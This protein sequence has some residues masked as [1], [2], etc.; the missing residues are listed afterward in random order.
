MVDIVTLAK[1]EGH[2]TLGLII[3]IFIALIHLAIFVIYLSN[4]KFTWVKR[5]IRFK[6]QRIKLTSL[7]VPKIFDDFDTHYEDYKEIVNNY[8]RNRHYL[9]NHEYIQE[10][11]DEMMM[12]REIKPYNIMV[13]FRDVIADD[14]TKKSTLHVSKSYKFESK[15]FNSKLKGD[16]YHTFNQDDRVDSYLFQNPHLN[17][18]FDKNKD[19]TDKYAILERNRKRTMTMLCLIARR[20]ENRSDT[21]VMIENMNQMKNKRQ[22]DQDRVLSRF[23]NIDEHNTAANM[24]II[25]PMTVHHPKSKQIIGQMGFKR[26][27]LNLI[28]SDAD[29]DNMRLMFNGGGDANQTFEDS[30]DIKQIKSVNILNKL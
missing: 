3:I 24:K 20:Q 13:D 4:I 18:I 26:E 25:N 9:L 7:D 29:N 30:M 1:A 5:Y 19:I 8:K 6:A 15:M 14:Y 12:N 11:R 2:Y 23:I 28:D 21:M 10:D 17:E 16:T 27:S 22:V